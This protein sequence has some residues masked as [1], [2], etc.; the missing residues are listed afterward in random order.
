MKISSEEIANLIVCPVCRSKL[1]L[2]EVNFVCGGDKKHTY[3]KIDGIPILINNKTSVF[4]QEDFV[5][6]KD[7]FFTQNKIS[8]L[9]KF[10]SKFVPQV[11][12]N[13][14]YKKNYH[15]F[16]ENIL[17]KSK[18][19]KVL[20]IGDSDL[21]L[22]I[23]IVQNND[24]ISLIVTDVSIGRETQV[25]CDAHNLPFK[26]SCF[27]GVVVQ[28]VLEHVL[29]PYKCVE[30]IHRVLKDE[31]IVYSSTPFM[32]QVHGGMYDFTR[33]TFLGHR[34]LFR[35]FKTIDD[36]ISC[37][38]GVA[39]AWSYKYFLLS[40]TKNPFMR[41]VLKLFAHLTSFCLKY[42][43]YLLS[44]RKEA[45]DAASGFYFLGEKTDKTLSDRELIKLYKGAY[46]K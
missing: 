3:P 17:Q 20:V 24:S 27:D 16:V 10:V 18:S 30:E 40:F 41:K 4:S 45:Y 33:F 11:T 23:G 21:G 7:T 13:V 26:N 42:F 29:D 6:K 36:G 9:E 8:S 5:N 38:P 46:D 39:L 19:P 14:S 1:S 44:R 25:V 35:K 37:G 2:T 12:S 32:Q 28:A 22:G 43:D 34:R 15:D 31:G